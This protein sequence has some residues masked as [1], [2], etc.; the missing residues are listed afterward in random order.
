MRE[1]SS[2]GP[3]PLICLLALVV[4]CA[5]GGKDPEPTVTP[6]VPPA[7]PTVQRPKAPAPPPPK[8]PPILVEIEPSEEERPQDS[9]SLV[10]ASREARAKRLAER[11]RGE[12]GKPLA[13]INNDNLDDF[14]KAGELTYAEASPPASDTPPAAEPAGV[15][16]YWRDRAEGLREEW[17]QVVEERKSLEDRA[18]LLRRRFY[19]EDDPFVRDG[20]IKPEWDQALERLSELR[21]DEQVLRDRLDELFAEGELAGADPGWLGEDDELE[22]SE[23]EPEQHDPLEPAGELEAHEVQD[24]PY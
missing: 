5:S 16:E 19:A 10:E 21:K 17:K 23:E 1:L 22:A 6:P 14:A 3:L 24:P 18:A 4:A 12:A 9:R 7:T 15:E 8:A 2:R 11:S 20:Q 13:V